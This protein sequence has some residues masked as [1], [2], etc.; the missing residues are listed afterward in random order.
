M[1]YQRVLLLN[2]QP[3]QTKHD[4]GFFILTVV[5]ISFKETYQIENTFM[6]QTPVKYSVG[7]SMPCSCRAKVETE[8][9]PK[10]ED[11]KDRVS[12]HLLL[13][14]LL[15]LPFKESMSSHLN[16]N[17]VPLKLNEI[18]TEVVYFVA[19]C[20]QLIGEKLLNTFS[21][22]KSRNAHAT[23]QQGTQ[24]HDTDQLWVCFFF[25]GFAVK[26]SCQV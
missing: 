13:L 8:S 4:L 21:L 7:F 11:C 1:V 5:N 19:I 14:L 17:S 25:S 9:E 6:S 24:L 20:M 22:R 10:F 23:K 16:L 15:L 3:F 26:M 2:K 18:Q 12:G